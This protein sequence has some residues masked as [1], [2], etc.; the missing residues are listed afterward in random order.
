MMLVQKTMGVKVDR[1][2]RNRSNAYQQLLDRPG[3]QTQEQGLIEFCEEVKGRHEEVLI[4]KEGFLK[5]LRVSYEPGLFDEILS[6]PRY[7][8]MAIGASNNVPIAIRAPNSRTKAFVFVEINLLILSFLQIAQ[9]R[10]FYFARL[11]AGEA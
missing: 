6:P 7:P 11:R 2:V 8:L 4:A 1:S 5:L 3:A 9:I 10:G